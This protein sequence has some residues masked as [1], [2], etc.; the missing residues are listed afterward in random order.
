MAIF[1]SVFF[2]KEGYLHWL[3]GGKLRLLLLCASSPSTQGIQ[4]PKQVERKKCYTEQ[5]GISEL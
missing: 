3:Q 2:L 5:K 1:M 4:A